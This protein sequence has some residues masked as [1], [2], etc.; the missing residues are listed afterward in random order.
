MGV[1]DGCHPE[2]HQQG[3]R[4]IWWNR[5][6]T[7][8]IS[9]PPSP[10]KK[11]QTYVGMHNWVKKYDSTNK[12][13]KWELLEKQSDSAIS[14]G[15]HEQ[16]SAV[17]GKIRWVQQYDSS[18]H[19]R[20]WDLLQKWRIYAA[21]EE[22]PKQLQKV[23]LRQSK[24][25]EEHDPENS[26]KLW[27]L[28]VTR[29]KLGGHPFLL[30]LMGDLHA[31]KFPQD[32]EKFLQIFDFQLKKDESN[33]DLK[34]QSINL[35]K[36]ITWIE[37]NLP[38]ETD[39]IWNLLEK[40]LSVD[41][42]QQ[43]S[44]GRSITL[45]QMIKWSEE[46]EPENPQKV[47]DLL[48]R[49]LEVDSQSGISKNWSITLQRMISWSEENE[50]ENP[51]K[52]WD[53]LERRLEVVSQSSD[54]KSESMTL[55]RMSRW[56]LEYDSVNQKRYWEILGRLLDSDEN[57]GDPVAISMTM[58]KMV[59]WLKENDSENIEM[60][61]DLVEEKIALKFEEGSNKGI[62]M[63]LREMSKL[64][65]ESENTGKRKAS[66]DY[67]LNKFL[68]R[69]EKI[70]ELLE[71]SVSLSNTGDSLPSEIYDRFDEN[72]DFEK[73]VRRWCRVHN[74]PLEG[75]ILSSNYS[76]KI[77]NIGI[78][79]SE[80]MTNLSLLQIKTEI[81]KIKFSEIQDCAVLDLPNILGWGK[82]RNSDLDSNVLD[83]ILK[84][85]EL[86]FE[87]TY[88]YLTPTTLTKYEEI[89]RNLIERDN[90][91]IL[92]GN[93]DTIEIKEDW[94]FLSFA[95]IHGCYIVSRDNFA[96][97][98]E[99]SPMIEKFLEKSRLSFNWSKSGSFYIS[100]IRGLEYLSEE[101]S[102]LSA[103]EIAITNLSMKIAYDYYGPEFYSNHID[104]ISFDFDSSKLQV[105]P[106]MS[107]SISR[108]IGRRGHK[109]KGL[110]D[111]FS[112][113]FQSIVEIEIMDSFDESD[114]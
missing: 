74:A 62:S 67:Y 114:L 26:E 73:F 33:N 50:P 16:S 89:V 93:S 85:A 104:Y 99:S 108:I 81:P 37:E 90:V 7:A 11:F 20:E 64:L 36:H 2:E 43:S 34:I 63:M 14:V 86:H 72:D 109:L 19:S 101:N 92:I 95:M 46:N 45:H 28:I 58:Q 107:E 44:I 21:E 52:V 61:W 31:E 29:Y 57:Q 13:R 94:I 23:L 91:E 39:K 3:F 47:W 113:K 65:Q 83:R 79:T 24:W 77:P 25:V 41:K 40:K 51:Q 9:P 32:H 71:L 110:Q 53:L 15:Y 112:E 49:K 60:I 66:F 75:W 55:N 102:E 12:L 106:R 84:E 88:V 82:R 42:R 18:N 78:Y 100:K 76:N 103:D 8:L 111:L 5:L 98:I 30:K 56:V 4:E 69:I 17:Q 97:E 68:K 38:E 10:E 80:E 59:N 48:E 54:Y 96:Q 1:C 35:S 27:E 6:E 87:S 70:G 22:D 105:H